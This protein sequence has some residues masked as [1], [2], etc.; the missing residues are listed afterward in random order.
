VI[1]TA[2]GMDSG[3][4]RRQKYT[5]ADGRIIRPSLVVIDD[6]QT[7]ESAYSLT[8]CEQRE[9][10]LLGDIL[11]MAGPGKE[12]AG[13]ICC[14]VIRQGDFADRLLDRAIHPAF[15]GERTKMLYAFPKRMELWE[16]Y[17]ELRKNSLVND[18]D[19]RAATEF[20]RDNQ[21]AMDEGAIVAWPE[22]RKP[23]DL[24]A[25]QTA[26]NLFFF[27]KTAF[28][29]EYQNS[30][31]E[32]HSDEELLTGPQIAAKLSGYPKRQV[33][34]ECQWLS[35]MIDVH[36]NLLFWAICGWSPNFSGWVLEYGTFPEQRARH[37]SLANAAHTMPRMFPKE[38]KEGAIVWRDALSIGKDAP[39]LAQ[40][41]AFIDFLISPEF[42]AEWNKAGGAPV[43]ANTVAVQSL[44][45]NSLTRK[46]LTEPE[47]L[48]RL[49]VEVRE[50][51]GR[52]CIVASR[53]FENFA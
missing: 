44:S 24:T 17:W 48:K 46:I 43:A 40:A 4:V 18:G 31:L 53:R 16:K 3:N 27:D 45:E 7:R 41:Y 13:I 2:T 14:T 38:N 10:I 35:A 32:E 11:G 33:P 21:A 26:M 28:F 47:A 30:P 52:S 1:I 22:R 39:N 5:R 20:Y 29:A 50:F 34:A 9:R 37:F 19:G 49:N 36:D 8:Q 15:Q 6:P 51:Y 12:I 42:F 23:D 25:L